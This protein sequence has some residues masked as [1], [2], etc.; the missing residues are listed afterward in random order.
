MDKTA[1]KFLLPTI[2]LIWKEFNL[3]MV[4]LKSLDLHSFEVKHSLQYQK[5]LPQPLDLS[6][7]MNKTKMGSPACRDDQPSHKSIMPK[8]GPQKACHEWIVG[9]LVK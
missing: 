4:A 6:F 8:Y 1:G 5:V 3:C 2:F 7:Q 9:R